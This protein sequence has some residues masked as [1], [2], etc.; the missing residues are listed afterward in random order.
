LLGAAAQYGQSLAPAFA[1]ADAIH[2]DRIGR[3]CD[4]WGETPSAI[5]SANKAGAEYVNRNGSGARINASDVLRY[6]ESIRS[7][8]RPGEKYSDRVLE[9]AQLFESDYARRDELRANARERERIDRFESAS[10]AG[11]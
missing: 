3:L 10:R 2:A 6:V 9:A 11:R 4:A 7:G 5:E 1:R 8:P